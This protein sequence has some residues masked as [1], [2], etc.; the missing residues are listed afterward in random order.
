MRRER[1]TCKQKIR[2]GLSSNRKIF[3][4]EYHFF[5]NHI[6]QVSG[7]NGYRKFLCPGNVTFWQMC[8]YPLYPPHWPICCTEF[9]PTQVERMRKEI[10]KNKPSVQILER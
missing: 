6:Q 4:I 8:S 5:A 3:H 7:V 1:V 10:G 2:A 9:A